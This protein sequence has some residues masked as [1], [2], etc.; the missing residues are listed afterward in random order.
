MIL[1]T[2]RPDIQFYVK[3]C[4]RGVPNP[5]ARDM[6]RAERICSFLMGTGDWTLKLEPW[7]DVDTLQMMVDSDWA[8]DKVDRRSTSAAVAQLGGC[9]IIT[10]RRTQGSPT[11]SSAEAEGY[12]LGSGVCE[13]L[14]ICAVANELGIELKWAPKSDSTA[15]FSQQT[16]MGLDRM[17]HVEL[18]FLFVKDLLKRERLTLCKV[19]GSEN[20]ADIG[21]TVLDG[22]THRYLCSIIG[23]S[24]RI[25]LWR[26]S[27]VTRETRN[28][29]E[30]LDC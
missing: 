23:L 16:K 8:T 11:M 18:R 10:N 20:P 13:G 28:L 12:A 7:K 29:L 14:F 25:R 26:R 22:N 27:R 21:T 3:E 19:P 24:L 1:A 17:K 4:A 9:T 15:T 30:V 5:S 6:Q 2:E